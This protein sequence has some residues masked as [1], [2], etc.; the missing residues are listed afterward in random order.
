MLTPGVSI[1]YNDPSP[2]EIY[3]LEAPNIDPLRLRNI[4]HEPN[5]VLG[6]AVFVH[7]DTSRDTGIRH[8]LFRAPGS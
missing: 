3:A 4:I 8:L 1:I 7:L 5:R 6:Q 2:P